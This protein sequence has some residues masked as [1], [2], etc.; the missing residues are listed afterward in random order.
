MGLF[1]GIGALRVAADACQLPVL[2]HISV[3]V[4]KE[5]SR[6]LESKFPSTVFVEAGV[7][8]VDD[9]MVRGWGMPLL[10]GSSCAPRSRPALPKCQWLEQ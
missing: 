6:A 2:G 5:A 8:A 7:E 4:K 10:P 9:E 3:E 1:D